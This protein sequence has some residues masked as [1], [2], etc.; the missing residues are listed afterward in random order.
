MG[1]IPIINI[2]N[3]GNAHKPQLSMS[4]TLIIINL[5]D[6]KRVSARADEVVYTTTTYT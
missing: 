5:V 6:S 4:L 1:S 2:L 3:Y